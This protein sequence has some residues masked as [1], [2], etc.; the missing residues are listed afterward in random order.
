MDSSLGGMMLFFLTGVESWVKAPIAI[1][2][3]PMGAGSPAERTK[4]ANLRLSVNPPRN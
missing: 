4:Y 1:C 3:P 2:T